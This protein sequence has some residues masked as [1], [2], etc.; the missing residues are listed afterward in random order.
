MRS[1]APTVSTVGSAAGEVLQ[2]LSLSLSL[3]AATATATPALTRLRTAVSC[4]VERPP[5]VPS[6]RLATAGAC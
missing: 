2:A 5:S 1:V 6:E 4:S 3:P